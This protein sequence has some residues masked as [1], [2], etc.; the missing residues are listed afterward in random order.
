MCSCQMY[1]QAYKTEIIVFN[2]ITIPAEFVSYVYN[3]KV[4]HL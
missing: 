4:M 1:P 2:G 3:S